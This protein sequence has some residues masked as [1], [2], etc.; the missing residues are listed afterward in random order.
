M[1]GEGE[2]TRG[3]DVVSGGEGRSEECEGRRGVG[4]GIGE[5]VRGDGNPKW[6]TRDNPEEKFLLKGEDDRVPT[7]GSQSIQQG[8]MA[9]GEED[10]SMA[11]EAGHE[12][13]ARHG[14]SGSDVGVHWEGP[15]TTFLRAAREVDGGE[16]TEGGGRVGSVGRRGC[17]ASII[18][19][20]GPL[21]KA[22]H[23]RGGREAVLQVEE[24]AAEAI[25]KARVGT[26]KGG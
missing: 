5:E 26:A 16:A 18:E 19:V 24:D 17:E 15:E 12:A 20:V 23:G 8:A 4:T 11:C 13:A 1:E 22:G 2:A 14:P 25:T 7:G 3:G 21:D 10:L 6:P 9:G